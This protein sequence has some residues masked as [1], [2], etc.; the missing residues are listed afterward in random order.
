M[1]NEQQNVVSGLA[2]AVSA[3]SLLC[4]LITLLLIKV[5]KKWNGFLSIL[6]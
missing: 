5:M 6:W 1:A 2:Y 4:T 3:I